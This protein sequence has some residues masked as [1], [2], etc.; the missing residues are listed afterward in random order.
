MLTP[1]THILPLTTITRARFLPIPGEVVVR[2]GQKVSPTDTIAEAIIPRGHIVMDVARE[3][4]E[5]P[6]DTDKLIKVKRGDMLEKDDVIAEISGLGG[7]DVV[8]PAAGRVVAIGGGKVLLQTGQTHIEVKAG[9]AGVVTTVMNARGAVVSTTGALVQGVW[10]NGQVDGGLLFSLC[11][12]P[13]DTL[14][15]DQLDVS[16]RGAVILAGHLDSQKALSVAA[17]LPLRG[18]ILSSI[19]PDL[20]SAASQLRFP[21]IVLDG[22]GKRPMTPAAHKL[23]S[24]NV[25]RDVAINAEPYDRLAGTRPEIVI[26]L[27]AGSDI[28]EPPEAVMLTAGQTVRLLRAPHQGETGVIT[29]VRPGLSQLPNGL[30][31]PAASVK[32]ESGETLLVPLANLEVLA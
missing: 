11:E 30:R 4:G 7:R 32:V 31:V 22:F 21:V 3:L 20:L 19:A 26:P 10:G 25:K 12:K 13:T 29:A 1:V 15:A 24:T 23:L 6:E 28:P 5:L 8:A 16:M 27:P 17:E 9:L 14:H 18:L 2:A